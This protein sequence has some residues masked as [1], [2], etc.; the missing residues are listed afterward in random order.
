MTKLIIGM[1]YWFKTGK[2]LKALN[3][4][5]SKIVC[6][7]LDEPIGL[8]NSM[9]QA[10]G[11][12]VE[13]RLPDRSYYLNGNDTGFTVTEGLWSRGLMRYK[14][15]KT[16]EYCSDFKWA[17]LLIAADLELSRRDYYAKRQKELLASMSGF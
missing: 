16:D 9:L 2:T 8:E 6:L 14:Q 12:T 10:N 13:F 7:D 1:V 17:K 15:I 4:L 3:K 5:Y 11:L